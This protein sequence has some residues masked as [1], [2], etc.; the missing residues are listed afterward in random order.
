MT[1]EELIAKLNHK[2]D[3]SDIVAWLDWEWSHP[4]W[5]EISSEPQF[6]DWF[7]KAFNEEGYSA[8][9][10]YYAYHSET[11]IDRE[12]G[13]HLSWFSSWVGEHLKLSDEN[14]SFP[15]YADA[16]NYGE[17]KY[18][19]LTMVGQGSISWLMTD[20]AFRKE[21]ENKENNK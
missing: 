20:E 10:E 15:L 21:Y 6:K 4:Q 14:D 9:D 5:L 11:E 18:W 17:E 12:L 1:N 13:S 7:N 16:F 2:C 8:T 3:I 19:V